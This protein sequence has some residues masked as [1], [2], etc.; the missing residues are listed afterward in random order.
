VLVLVLVLGACVG[1]PAWARGQTCRRRRC[2]ALAAVVPAERRPTFAGLHFFN[3]VP[4]MSLV[5]VIKGAR[6]SAVTCSLPSPR[7]DRSL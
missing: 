5:E 1:L 7:T 4:V 3:P 2:Q 6:W